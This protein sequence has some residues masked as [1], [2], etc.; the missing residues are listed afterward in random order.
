MR[1]YSDLNSNLYDSN[2]ELNNLNSSNL[3][4]IQDS[5][6]CVNKKV[7]VITIPKDIKAVSF[8]G[9]SD[10]ENLTELDIHDNIVSIGKSA[11]DN[12]TKLETIKISK[13]ITKFDD[14]TFFNCINL[15][16]IN[17][18]E[19]IVSIGDYCFYNCKSIDSL[20]LPQS[21]DKIGAYCF[22]HCEGASTIELPKKLNE[23]A[24]G[25]F[26]KCAN[27]KTIK[28]PENIDTLHKNLFAY[29]SSL[30]E[31]DIPE[32]IKH[33]NEFTFYN[34]SSLKSAK[35]H[36]SIK[37]ISPFAFGKCQSLEQINLP[38]SLDMLSPSIFEDCSSLEK[39]TLPSNTKIISASLF[40]NCSSL[41]NLQIPKGVVCI[42]HNAFEGCKSL[43]SIDLPEG[44]KSI[45]SSAFY[46]C[47]GLKN[48]ELPDDLIDLG[49]DV[50]D[51]CKSLEEIKIP[52]NISNLPKLTFFNC[53][54]LKNVIL[55]K[56]L[57]S[58]G[59]KCFA[60]CTSLAQIDLKNE[61]YSIDN[62]AF[63][64]CES[65]TEV[66]FP[67]SLRVISQNAF[68]GCTNLHKVVI[69]EKITFIS[70]SAFNNCPNLVIH[71]P[72]DSY[73]HKYA[74]KNGIAFEEFN[75]IHLR[76]IHF[77]NKSIALNKG[78]IKQLDLIITPEDTNDTFN[79]TW[80]S[81]DEDIISVDNKG[82]ITC[83]SIG[84]A[85]ITAKTEKKSA[86]CVVL[87]NIK[88]EEIKLD[89]TTLDLTK[90]ETV[91]LNMS[92]F[93]SEHLLQKDPVWTTTDKSVATVDQDGNVKAI[94]PGKCSI[95][96][97]LE[98]KSVSCD[99]DIK[100]PVQ[101]IKFDKSTINA[102]VG[103]TFVIKPIVLPIDTT[104]DVK[105]EWQ[106][107]NSEIIEIQNN[108]EIKALTEGKCVLF[109]SYKDKIATC[110]ISI[111]SNINSIHFKEDKISLSPNNSLALELLDNNGNQIDIEKVALSI[112]DPSVAKIE[113]NNVIAIKEGLTVI[114][115]QM[116]GLIATCILT[117]LPDKINLFTLNYVKE[118]S[119]VVSGRGLEGA[120]VR[121]FSENI[122]ISEVAI[123][124]EKQKFVL[125][126]DNSKLKN[127][128]TVEISKEGYETRRET[129]NV[130]KEFKEFKILSI[131]ETSDSMLEIIGEGLSESYIRAYIKNM[132]IGTTGVVDENGK[133]NIQ[134]P[135][136]KPDTTITLKMRKTHYV[137][138][139][140]NITIR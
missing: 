112:A 44:L 21:T 136:V 135:R 61:L 12:C 33:I 110:I 40:K 88:L 28:I 87:S 129:I 107:S 105:L 97:T 56:N 73:A 17:I 117:V 118:S 100:I 106:Y 11:F 9:F 10:C 80:H 83:N 90:N 3:F 137:T 6:S 32:N 71:A 119:T 132:Q 84:S 22:K 127:E 140:K 67:N 31:V 25:A 37:S 125:P 94:T 79:I 4:Q 8:L 75:F 114:I 20:K 1:K 26:F 64:N 108:N 96:C 86:Q 13:N 76:R 48:I 55:P 19:N 95:I 68:S 93:P 128:V 50:F 92:Y 72:K 122:P 89:K 29:C 57:Y 101:E 121:A 78:D 59:Y 133:F 14:R 24:E 51:S 130:L 70:N 113:N 34:C 7:E 30:E 53:S 91:K 52:K 27:L 45:S 120:S 109:A 138:A 99:V 2:K 62:S 60:N 54:E 41:D 23:L 139:L 38:D 102:K 66:N 116:Q 131:S 104:D 98:D 65:L 35:L 111:A 124:D 85:T 77:E 123:V 115:A 49:S 69:P 63:E 18:P 15:K 74:V 58:I 16:N 103:E 82:V 47:E 42:K 43:S 5:I 134:V 46:K 126:I 81:S 39:A 36:S